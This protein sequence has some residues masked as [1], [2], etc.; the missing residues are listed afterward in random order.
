[1]AIVYA[2]KFSNLKYI[3]CIFFTIYKKKRTVMKKFVLLLFFASIV[4][5]CC[6]FRHGHKD[7]DGVISGASMRTEF[8]FEATMQQVDSVC[9]ADTLPTLNK[10]LSRKF[11]DFETGFI[12]EKLMYI[13]VLNNKKEVIYILLIDKEEPYPFEKRVAEK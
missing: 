12:N 7:K 8:S 10:W 5:S 13:K 9:I 4:G 1:M 2:I 6:L 11:E 3:N